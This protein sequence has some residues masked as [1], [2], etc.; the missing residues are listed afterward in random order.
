MARLLKALAD[1]FP[2]RRKRFWRYV[3]PR[4][5][6][7]SLVGLAILLVAIAGYWHMTNSQRIRIRAEKYLRELTGCY[8][9]IRDAKFR[10]FGQVELSGVSVNLD[11]DGLRKPFFS[12]RTVFLRHSP[13][14]LLLKGNF[15]PTEVV[16][17]SPVVTLLHDGQGSQELFTW[18]TYIKGA[19]SNWQ[20]LMPKISVRGGQ[21]SFVDAQTNVQIFLARDVDVTMVPSHRRKY[22]VA[23]Q[24][25]SGQDNRDIWGKF[26]VDLETGEVDFKKG[27]LPIQ[28]FD[29]AL[30]RKYRTWRQRYKVEGTLIPKPSDDAPFT[31]EHLRFELI[32][33][34]LQL[35][36]DEG[37]LNL[38]H[39]SGHIS[40]DAEGITLDDVSGQVTQAGEAR[41]SLTGRYYGYQMDSPF[42]LNIEVLGGP[43]GRAELTDALGEKFKRLDE[44]LSPVGQVNLLANMQRNKDGQFLIEGQ[45]ELVGISILYEHFPYKLEKVTGTLEFKGDRVELKDI[46]VERGP[47]RATADGYIAGLGKELFYDLQFNILDGF[48]IPLDEELAQA[49]PGQVQQIWQAVEPT[50][51]SGGK[52]R[53]HR[54]LDEPKGSVEIDMDLAGKTSMTYSGFPYP[55]KDMY[56]RISIAGSR[57]DID[58]IRSYRGQMGCRIE[59]YL[60]AIGRDAQAVDLVIKAWDAPIDEVLLRALAHRNEQISHQ[61]RPVGTAEQVQASISQLPGQELA[62]EVTA[63]FVGSQFQIRQFPYTISDASGKIKIAGR[64]IRIMDLTGRHGSVPVSI[65][66]RVWPYQ[67]KQGMD[68]NLTARDLLL[69]DD[70]YQALSEKLQKNWKSLGLSGTVDA[71]LWIRH[72]APQTDGELD[73]ALKINAKDLNVQ[74]EGF[75]YP[76]TG[77]SG[78]VAAVPGRIE[79]GSLRGTD[80]SASIQISGTILQG[81]T[82][83]EGELSVQGKSI[84]VDRKLLDALPAEAAPLVAKLQPAGVCDI[85]L[86]P[87]RF[88]K[89]I[90]NQASNPTTQ[91]V[92]FV[93]DDRVDWN[94]EGSV[95]VK[96]VVFDLGFGPKTIT[97]KIKGSGGKA[98]GEL[99]LDAEVDLSSVQ[100]GRRKITDLTGLISKEGPS[101]T[102][103]I[104]ELFGKAMGGRMAGFADIR[105]TNPLQYR[106]YLDI[107]DIRLE[108]LVA[109]SSGE[110]EDPDVQ[111]L[112]EGR[113]ELTTQTGKNARRQAS[114]VLVIS[115]AKLKKLPVVL[116]L[117]HVVTVAL[118]AES[119]LSDGAITYRV[120]GDTL[121]L[122]EIHFNG[123]SVG[124]MGPTY[125]LVGTGTIDMKTER[126]SLTFISDPAGAL[127]RL[128]SFDELLSGFVRELVEIQITGTLSNPKVRTVPLHSIEQA[129]RKL[130]S[131]GKQGDESIVSP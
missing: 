75:A 32:D 109:D 122:E 103:H 64:S 34:S 21:M 52:I 30:P 74:Y 108:E 89:T 111:G 48:E 129:M 78:Q 49:L 16:C 128:K 60:E 46:L 51:F 9:S 73:F 105:L 86:K 96:G 87:L 123:P 33:V 97:G 54:M 56:G 29:E 91:P 62:I 131:P 24:G 50:G 104:K 130:L 19:G 6:N 17:I 39:V 120:D 114:G 7:V 121:I 79:I 45:A 35:P 57:I 65:D 72:N 13:A 1:H 102:I 25:R 94:L 99:S 115:Q 22:D 15:E 27:S 88:V 98:D 43:L 31:P 11:V 55:L 67:E 125:S 69:D 41:F 59:G 81:P 112:L 84:P 38:Q 93:T 58:A 63:K 4:R 83:I 66:G 124:L 100:V 127:P 2:R 101:Q 113:L 8:V 76:L 40:F 92:G 10:M 5:R 77:L 85:D 70:L 118:P 20:G 28:S 90:N 68:L 42:E 95:D 18:A 82:L 71:Q 119:A 23:F 26:D 36:E 117:L 80:G 53:L 61:I 47:A 126:L 106:L 3:S 37:G 12:A 14:G 107:E 44:L 110:T 116:G